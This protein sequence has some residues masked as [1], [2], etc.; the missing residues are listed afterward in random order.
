MEEKILHGK[1]KISPW[2]GKLSSMERKK[3]HHGKEKSL[4][5]KEKSYHGKVKYQKRTLKTLHH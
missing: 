4:P 3:F 1:K 2:K 5:W